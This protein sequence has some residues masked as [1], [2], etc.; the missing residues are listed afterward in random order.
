M[1]STQKKKLFENK[2]H[3]FKKKKKKTEIRMWNT[4]CYSA[5][6]LLAG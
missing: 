6:I 2:E 3:K 1:D 4:Y 5:G